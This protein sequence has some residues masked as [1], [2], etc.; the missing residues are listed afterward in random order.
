MD[1]GPRRSGE[2]RWEASPGRRLAEAVLKIKT[3]TGVGWA[4][5]KLLAQAKLLDQL[6]ICPG[7]LAFEIVE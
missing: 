1:S 4:R 2:L 3:P 5:E 6:M 7:V